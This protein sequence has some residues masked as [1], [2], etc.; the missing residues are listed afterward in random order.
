MAEKQPESSAE[1]SPA[2]KPQPQREERRREREQAP[3][4]PKTRLGILV[5]T[6]KI[7]SMDEIFESGQRIKE[8]GIV[9][10]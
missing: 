2:P 5:S 3:W 1:S 10:M 9:K 6:G 8:A 7:T 4:V